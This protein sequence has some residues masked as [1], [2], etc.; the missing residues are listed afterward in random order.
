ML[1]DIAYYKTGGSCET[2]HLPESIEQLSEIVKNLHENSTP[3]FVIGG[4]T[5]SLVLDE[6]YPGDVIAFI[7]MKT[8]KVDGSQVFVEAGAENTATSLAAYEAGLEGISWMNR[9][10]G[11]IGGTVRMNAKCYGGEISQVVDEVQVVTKTGEIKTYQ[12]DGSLFTGYKDT[13]FMNN[14]DIIASAT[15]QLEAGDSASIKEHMDHCERDRN[16]KGQFI[17]PSCGCV[18]KNDYSVGVPSGMLLDA[19]GAHSLNKNSVAL[20]P[21]HANFVFN[22]GAGSDEILE[23]TFNMREL[24]F[25]TFGVW[26]NYEMEILGKLTPPQMVKV[27]EFKKHRFNEKML[28]P[29]RKA[30]Q[31]NARS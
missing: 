26:L 17:Y 9:L 22:K 8:I 3:Y 16:S 5:N 29:L 2:L 15:I 20:N 14:G 18:F 24:V 10:P 7:K 11:Q 23:M 19:A 30:F 27:N 31:E 28:A 25:R 21:K 6:H 12:N 1:K 4:G 13:V